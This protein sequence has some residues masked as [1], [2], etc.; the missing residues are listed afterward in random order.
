MRIAILAALL[1]AAS[2][3]AGVAAQ[4]WAADPPAKVRAAAP[5]E[6]PAVGVAADE[7]RG[8]EVASR[9]R[10]SVA[11]PHAGTLQAG[12]S[13][14][15]QG[16]LHFHY[17][18]GGEALARNLAGA[19]RAMAPLPALPH[20]VLAVGDPI[21]IYLAPDPARFDSLTGGRAPEW[22]A[23][24]A[25]PGAGIIVLPAYG[26][27][28]GAPHGLARVLRH[29]LAHIAIARHTAPARVPRWFD[30]GYARW[31]AGEWDADSAWQL[32]MAFALHRAPPLDSLSLEWPRAEAEARIAYLLATSA[33]AY[34]V[35]HGG[36]EGLE[37]LLRRWRDSGSF[38][39]ALRDTYGRTVSQFEAEW[40]RVV[41]RRY[42]WLFALSHSVVFWAFGASLLLALFAIRRRRD[43]SRL[44][45]LRATEPPDDPAYW[46]DPDP[47][48]EL[49]E[50]G[51]GPAAQGGETPRPVDDDGENL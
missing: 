41:K 28:R 50:P 46:L 42:G 19:V 47:V 30:E 4:P 40:V 7:A 21:D 35:E 36:V 17:W 27:R 6:M 9:A 20:D 48:L 3:I 10:G 15:V 13:A 25:M 49:P 16:N 44:E 2:P 31:A 32:R 34:L 14:L 24:V 45:R 38:D 26:S 18:P 22:G 33:V 51:P 8:M 37:L 1:T 39:A 5:T 29:E 12:R 23:G 11:H 43:R